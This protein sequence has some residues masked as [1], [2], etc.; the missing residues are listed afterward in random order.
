VAEAVAR[1]LTECGATPGRGAHAP[2]L[3]AGRTA[4][5]CRR[6]VQRLLE[7]PGDPGRVAFMPNA[8][9]ALNTALW[10]VL[11]PGDA[12]VVSAYDHNAVLRPVDYLARTRSVEVRSIG[13]TP[14]GAVDY[15]EAERLLAGAR[16]LVVNS[17][18]NVLGHRLPLRELAGR[19]H[20]AGAL[21]LLD[22][23]QGAGHL[24]MACAEEGADLVAFTGHKGMLG[25]Q[26]TGGLWTRE[27]V[28]I[29]PM[30]RGGTGG[31]SRLRDMPEPLPDRLEAGTVNAPG[32]AGLEAG[33]AY[34]LERGV[35]ALHAHESR[36]KARLREGLAAI[37]GVRVRSPRAPDGVGI[38]TF[39]VDA[40]DPAT[41]ATRLEQAWGVQGR[42]GLHCAPEAH[43]LVGT[44]DT[45]A[46]RLSVGWASTDADVERALEG[47]DALVGSDAAATGA[48]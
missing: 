12:V 26:G 1:F 19:A 6:A 36:L 46:L 24:P 42:A 25:P 8:T 15:E 48:R 17:A 38:V 2:A 32:L 44:L 10:G 37:P 47:V 16:L 4:L 18:S 20:A 11:A 39:T 30:M 40:M 13:G 27:G 34:V 14:E 7:L 43:R 29:E 33:I 35:E 9:W 45:G 28:D 31:D 23:A 21:V 3:E 22:A 41:L 5:G